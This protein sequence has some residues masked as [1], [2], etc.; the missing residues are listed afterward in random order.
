[1]IRHDLSLIKVCLRARFWFAMLDSEN[2]STTAESNAPAA[3]TALL[4]TRQTKFD[5]FR[6]FLVIHI[7]TVGRQSNIWTPD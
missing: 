2:D 1:M 6:Y 7:Y 4:D 3:V 5:G